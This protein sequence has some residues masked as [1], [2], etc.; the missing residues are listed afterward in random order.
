VEATTINNDDNG[1]SVLYWLMLFSRT[2][3][4]LYISPGLV[5][6]WIGS[7]QHQCLQAGKPT[8]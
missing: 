6:T 3:K 1:S 2:T 7:H 8:T 5:T 4:L